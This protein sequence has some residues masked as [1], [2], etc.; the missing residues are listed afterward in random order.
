MAEELF[1]NSNV[2]NYRA[3]IL[4]ISNDMD[5]INVMY[6]NILEVC[7]EPNDIEYMENL[8]F[9]SCIGHYSVMFVFNHKLQPRSLSFLT[10]AGYI[11][12]FFFYFY[13]G[14]FCIQ[15]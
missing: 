11:Y 4:S 6:G 5:R 15:S 7:P 8:P 9:G 3:L 10:A 14:N 13:D 2:N 12:V 1:K